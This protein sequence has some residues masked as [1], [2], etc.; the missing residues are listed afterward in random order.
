[1]LYQQNIFL[2]ALFILASEL[3]FATMGASV[4]AVSVELPNEMAVFMRNLFGLLFITLWLSRNGLRQLKTDV[5]HIHLLRACLG[6][7]AMYCFFYALAHL[8]LAAGLLLKM[9]APFFMPF[10]AYVWLREQAPQLALLALPVGFAGVVL[11][12]KPEGDF[13][14][15][16]LIGILGGLLAA[17]AKVTVRRLGHSE[18][19]IR[20]VFYF[21]FIASLISS[22]P[23]IWAWQTPSIKAWGLLVLMGAVGTLGQLLLTRAYAIARTAQIAPFTYFS[24][25]YGAIYGYVFWQEILDW[26]FVGG[27]ILIATAGLMAI[28][29]SKEKIVMQSI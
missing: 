15:V 7:A 21:S 19:T 11:V 29:P 9:T 4:K 1:M 18:P 10:I 13:N 8:P 6:L 17:F 27:A 3:M 28:K 2:G 14:W 16:A 24:V 23:L 26:Y 22:V 12:L 25:V 20:V 5:M